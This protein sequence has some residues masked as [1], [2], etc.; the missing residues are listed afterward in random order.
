MTYMRRPL[1]ARSLCPSHVH[2]FWRRLLV[3]DA[4]AGDDMMPRATALSIK[5]LEKRLLDYVSEGDAT[6]I[7]FDYARYEGR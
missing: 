5:R 6:G 1:H 4:H 2:P 3:L 7:Y